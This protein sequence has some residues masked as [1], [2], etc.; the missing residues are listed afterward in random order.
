MSKKKD[1]AKIKQIRKSST[2]K[3]TLDDYLKGTALDPD[4][5]RDLVSNKNKASNESEGNKPTQIT[6]SPT[7]NTIPEASHKHCI[8][9]GASKKLGVVGESRSISCKIK[10]CFLMLVLSLLGFLIGQYFETS[11]RNTV[12]VLNES[13]FLKLA[14]IGIATS[15]KAKSSSDISEEDKNK[16]RKA[17]TQ[18]TKILSEQYTKYPILI[19][20]RNKQGYDIYSKAKHIDITVPVLIQLIGEERWEEIG[21][22]LK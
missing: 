2:A 18:V 15:D 1:R 10:C 14:S 4:I 13:K 5:E 12:Y 9:T 11:D 20:K 19:Q 3:V 6:D 7:E 21:K 17:I 8:Q 16:V 22:V